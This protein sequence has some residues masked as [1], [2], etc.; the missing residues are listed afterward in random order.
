MK[1]ICVILFCL[2]MAAVAAGQ[3]WSAEIRIDGGGRFGPLEIDRFAL[4]RGG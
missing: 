4:E 3:R 2:I 1:K